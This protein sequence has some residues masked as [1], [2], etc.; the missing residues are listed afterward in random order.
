MEDSEKRFVLFCRQC[1]RSFWAKGPNAAYC[2][3]CRASRK[4]ALDHQAWIR[5][6]LRNGYNKSPAE[7]KRRLVKKLEVIHAKELHIDILYYGVWKNC[8]P[9]YYKAWMEKHLPPELIDVGKPLVSKT[10]LRESGMV[11]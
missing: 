6:K 3:E 5:R 7:K 11:N 1:G 9:L 2:E 10:I 4:K 8:H